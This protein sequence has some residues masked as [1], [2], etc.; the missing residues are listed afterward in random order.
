MPVSDVLD[1]LKLNLLLNLKT[2]DPYHDM[3]VS[4]ILTGIITLLFSHFH[5]ILDII[6]VKKISE[7]YRSI[8]AS[9]ITIDGK[10][11]F[12]TGYHCRYNNIWSKRFDA[13]WD[14]INV[15]TEYK[16]I[17]SLKEMMGA[18]DPFDEHAEEKRNN[19]NNDIFVIDQNYKSF[20]FDKDKNIYAFVK[21]HD[22]SD[23]SEK[24]I[25]VQG[26][27]ET[28][29]IE[30]FSYTL[31]IK[32]L[33]NYVDNITLNYI[34]KIEDSRNNKIF[35]YQLQKQ[36]GEDKDSIGLSWHESIFKSNRQFNNIYFDGKDSLIKKIDFFI[37]NKEWYEKEGHPYTLGIGLSGPPGTGKTSVIKSI[38]NKTKRH[39][40]EI[41]LN[42]IK[43]ES[44]F[45]HYYF[46]N[47][48]N[49]SNKQNS[50]DFDKK[51]IVLE[52]VDCMSDI[53]LD[54]ENR[55]DNND[56]NNNN[57]NYEMLES[58]V[59]AVSKKTDNENNKNK[60]DTLNL[61]Q[62]DKQM[63]LSFILNLLDGLNENHGRILIITSNYYDK[64]D[65]ALIR[66]G[67][68]DIKVN[69]TKASVNTIKTMYQHYFNSNIPSKYISKLKNDM[70]SPA[71]IVNIYRGCDHD[72][73]LFIKNIITKCS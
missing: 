29:S 2:G 66:P 11:T 40:I 34:K 57:Q 53:I 26:K 33:K 43:S 38:A 50:I 36:K 9:R 23:E 45:F 39:L 17:N 56:I 41:P 58:L 16:G 59:N 20:L 22:N 69:M 10:R 19:I 37:N 60:N 31:T 13:L 1:T 24:M 63:S 3:I 68:I 64:I 4:A 21:T 14:Y 48:Y 46:E 65:K 67:R 25:E 32:E 18:I 72:K 12:R 61:F 44:D 35:L 73:N 7:T 8:F 28:I 6:T 5:N 52:D 15:N 62:K 71:E 70:I 51:I 55:N 30:L 49:R 42:N 47:T 54:R 27:V